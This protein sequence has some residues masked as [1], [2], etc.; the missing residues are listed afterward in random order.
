MSRFGRRW[1]IDWEGI[2]VSLVIGTL[3]FGVAY[4][5]FYSITDDYYG[6]TITTQM[7]VVDKEKVL[8]SA[9][10]VTYS[11]RADLLEDGTTHQ[12]VSFLHSHWR[13]LE[14][15]HTYRMACIEGYYSQRL[16]S[17]SP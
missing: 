2:V 5:L 9:K 13:Q 4:T 8:T 7:T 1:D 12:G 14:I 16:T 10:P 6:T 15:G 11:Y 17:C 3:L